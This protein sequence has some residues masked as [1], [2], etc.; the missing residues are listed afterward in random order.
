MNHEK[1]ERFASE[2]LGGAVPDCLPDELDAAVSHIGSRLAS[3]SGPGVDQVRR[4]L[5]ALNNDRLFRPARTL[6]ESWIAGRGFDLVVEKRLVQAMIEMD[7]L[8]GAQERLK[9][10]IESAKA[11]DSDQAR[12]ELGEYQGQQGRIAKQRFVR[13]NNPDELARSIKLY[14]A[15]YLEYGR[16]Y[17]HG[18]N[19]AA[20]VVLVDQEVLEVLVKDQADQEATVAQEAHKELE[21]ML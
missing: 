2:L 16:P 4:A 6:A 10:A 9:D 11:M 21:A 12:V 14:A 7:D 18:I 1:V 20:L 5:S 8:D 3:P 17:R 19:L 15:A 13:S